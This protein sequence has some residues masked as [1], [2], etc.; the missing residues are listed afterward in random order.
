[1]SILGQ[2]YGEAKGIETSLGDL[3]KTL[4][5][6]K[7]SD[8]RSNRQEEKYRQET[9]KQ[10]KRARQDEKRNREVVKEAFDE[11]VGPK[12]GK[13]IEKGGT[14][15]ALAAALGVAV[16]GA[17]AVRN[18]KKDDKEETPT[19]SPSGSGGT[20]KEEKPESTP[21]SSSGTIKT[22]EVTPE[23]VTGKF[24]VEALKG[25][26]QIKSADN[27][28]VGARAGDI[29]PKLDTQALFGQP[30]EDEKSQALAGALKDI[31]KNT[32][33]KQSGG[34]TGM[35]PNVG[36][37][38][39]G[40]H[41]FTSVQPGSYIMNRNLVGA[42]GYQSGGVP[43]ALEQGE[44]A[45]PPGS[46]DQ[47]T[48]DFLNYQA[49]PR[50]QSGGLVEAS[51]PATGSGYSIGKDYKGRPAVFSK[52]AAEALMK[53]IADS[54][55]V[56]K[57]SDI[58][59]SKRS[60]EHN[61]K[62]GG[63]PRSNHLSGNA[64]DI[65]GTS[66]VWL[67][68][69]GPKYGWHNLNYSGHDGHFDFKGGGNS[70]QPGAQQN[71]ITKEGNEKTAASVGN[72]GG[73]AVEGAAT[74]MFAKLGKVGKVGQQILEAI[75][76]KFMK[77]TG[78]FDLFNLGSAGAG[79]LMQQFAG[80]QGVGGGDNTPVKL[81]S[82][83]GSLKS[84]TDEQWKELAYIVSGEAERG[85]DDE[86]GVA[87][88][89]LNRVADS[90]FPSTIKGVGAQ[91]GQFEAVYSGLA[92]HEPELAKKL[93][94]NQSKIAEAMKKLQGRTD[95]KGVTQYGN[96]GESD[97][98]FSKA[99]NFYHYAEQTGKGTPVPK[100]KPQEWKQWVKSQTG[101]SIGKYMAG[102]NVLAQQL[103]EQNMNYRM[104]A[105]MD[106]EP[107]I[108]ME[109]P[110]STTVTGNPPATNNNPQFLPTRCSSWASA[111]LEYRERSFNIGY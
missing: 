81:G 97:I 104:A 22:P 108:V 13:K 95:F 85:T 53:A 47:G 64:V 17:M 31:L 58:T 23:K 32:Q 38:A 87:A 36:Q 9:L 102:G 88:A 28:A 93:K 24:Q 68:E 57:A 105:V 4:S 89:V 70:Q 37:P 96:M 18:S 86:Y 52:A 90:R 80:E 1:M 7:D 60:A 110:P 50:F 54:N 39:T 20:E 109:D 48:M 12:A 103:H 62:V 98:R 2:L 40:D 94:Q 45:L 56:V 6:L 29:T 16:A 3:N 106:A 84:M 30:S 59:S 82:G 41:F 19:P 42:M 72:E 44:I 27:M 26:E 99:G 8:K 79:G 92:R 73:G 21:Q 101:G 66:K 14:M 77:A 91:Q 51:H 107:I 11:A 75:N 100:D 111:I 67:K 69:H 5:Q 34:F 61:A 49:F 15:A 10:N 35:V 33:Q 78:G 74:G 76:A 65:H 71:S 63:V 55:G 25:I 46:Y 43:V 83:S